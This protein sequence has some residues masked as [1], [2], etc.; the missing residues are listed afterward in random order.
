[1]P[2][3]LV[4]QLVVRGRLIAPVGDRDIQTLYKLTRLSENVEEIKIED[5]GGCR[6]VSLIGESGWKD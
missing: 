6:F 3:Y 2:I 4:Q 5:L 1:M